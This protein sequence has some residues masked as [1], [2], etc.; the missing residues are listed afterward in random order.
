MPSPS[1][2]TA[3][4]VQSAIDNSRNIMGELR[5]PGQDEH[6]LAVALELYAEAVAKRLSISVTVRGVELE[7]RL[8]R[9]VETTLFRITQEAINNLAKHANAQA[10]EISLQEEGQE[11]RMTITDDGSGFDV[12]RL[13]EAGRYGFQIMR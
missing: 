8:P 6:G 12:N 3:Y 7:K 2:Q 1:T 13:P 4:L 10:V 11:V 5:P 9:L